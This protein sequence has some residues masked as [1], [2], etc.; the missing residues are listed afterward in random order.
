VVGRVIS[1]YRALEK[2]GE[3]G[4]GEVYKAQDL[5]LDRLVALKLLRRVKVIDADCKRRFVL[6]AKAASALNH[7]NI[8]TI[9]EIA[10]QDGLDFIVMEFLPGRTLDQVVRRKGLNTGETLKYAV[11]IASAM[12]SA[13]AAG[14]I[15]RDLKPSNML[16]DDGRVKVLDFGLAKLTQFVRDGENE[17]TRTLQPDVVSQDG[18]IAGT[19]AY[20]SPEQAQGLKLDARS[21]IFSFSSVLYEL[22]TG[23][24]PFQRES[25]VSTLAAILKEEPKAIDPVCRKKWNA[26]SAAV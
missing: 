24:R 21:D 3:G 14:I 19:T 20:M 26:F 9:H 2:L 18:T 22:L 5:S 8:V 6:E 15:H 23:E 1:H 11:Q 7:P 17:S 4:M 16:M 12:S 10:S 25:T 13:H